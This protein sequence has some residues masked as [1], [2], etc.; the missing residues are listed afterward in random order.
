MKSKKLCVLSSIVFLF[1]GLGS[2][3]LFQSANFVNVAEAAGYTP[4]KTY[5][6]H[7][8]ATY[9]NNIS[10]VKT[11]NDLLKDLRTLNGQKRQS[12]VGYSSMGTSS[13]GA[14]KYTDFSSKCTIMY[15]SKNQPYSTEIESFYSHKKASSFNREHVWPNTHGGGNVDDDIHMTRPTITE[16]NGSRGHSYYIEGKCGPQNGWDP[17]AE[18]KFTADPTSRGEAARIIFYCMTASSSLNINDDESMSNHTNDNNMGIISDLIKWHL[19][20]PITERENNRNEGAEYL[21]GNRNAFI[22]HPEYVCK[23][24]GNTNEKTRQLCANDPYAS[25]AP[26]SITLNVSS[27]EIVSEETFQLFVN[28]VVPEDANRGVTWSSSNTNVATVDVNGLVKGKATGTSIVT[29][30]S[31]LD[32]NVKATCTINVTQREDVLL[33]DFTLSGETSIF[34]GDSTQLNVTFT[35]SNV[36]PIPSI[37]YLSSDSNVLFVNS[38]GIATGIKAGSAKITAKATQNSIVIEKSI[39]IVVKEKQATEYEKITTNVSVE[40][41]DKIVLATGI[42]NSYI[43]VTGCGKT[44]ALVSNNSTL[45]KNYKAKVTTN[46]KFKLYDETENKYIAAPTKNEFVYGDEG[47]EFTKNSDGTVAIGDRFLY[48][49]NNEYYRFYNK[50]TEPTYTYFYMY[51]VNGS[52]PVPPQPV[53]IDIQLSNV[54]NTA[55]V[56]S[57]FVMPKVEA[58][59]SDDS[60]KDVTAEAIATG[61]NMKVAGTYTV[62]ITYQSMHKTYTLTVTDESVPNTGCGGNVVTTSV[63]LAT[64]SLLGVG[65]ILIR[66]RKE[67]RN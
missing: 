63:V 4:S 31:V 37:S 27:K 12:T 47:G 16:E 26:T 32:S 66:M 46:G 62:K 35:P 50:K 1:I 22:D 15:D 19:Q 2:I 64:M 33:E 59:Y 7:D 65:I 30:T 41:D 10:T 44:D 29:A 23:I 58:I 67:N 8:A 36:Y 57:N 55:K 17:V 60:R 52:Q 43:G 28:G 56:N 25:K 24:W 42:G 21:Q 3:P 20:Y 53:L 18:T 9:Y 5:Q 13:S 61:Y 39:T 38:S 40:N 14:F 49:N 48:S 51:K 45:W 11:G 34:E 6:N 54:V